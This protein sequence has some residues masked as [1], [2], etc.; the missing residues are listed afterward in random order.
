M[1]ISL[2]FWKRLL[3][4]RDMPYAMQPE[5]GRIAK[6]VVNTPAGER[7]PQPRQDRQTAC[8]SRSARFRAAV[9]ERCTSARLRAAVLGYLSTLSPVLY[10]VPTFNRQLRQSW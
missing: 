9:S 7:R 4:K 1:A 8:A 3:P 5:A 2:S 6:A 10:R